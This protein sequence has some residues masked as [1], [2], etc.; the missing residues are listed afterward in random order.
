MPFLRNHLRNN[1]L[2]FLVL[3]LP[4]AILARFLQWGPVWIFVLSAVGLIPMAGYIGKAT[5]VLSVYTG[6]RIGGLLNATLGNAAELIITLVAIRAGLLDL[7][8]ASITG[9]IIGNLLLV[10]GMAMLVGGVKNGFQTFDRRHA[11]NNSVLLILAILALVI[12]SVF[13]G[14]IGDDGSPGV[15]SL[16][17][18]VAVVMMAL[19]GLG[20]LFAVKSAR[21]PIATETI[22]E[23]HHKPGMSLL[24]SILLLAVATL[25][26]V[27]LSELLVGE[28]EHVTENLGLSEFFLGIILV[29]IIGNV[30]EHLVA[31]QVAHRNHMELSVEIAISSSL[32]IAL[33]VAPLL[34][35]LS[36]AM[37]NPLTLIFNPF[38]LIALGAGVIISALVSLDGESNWLEG[39]ALMAV[40]LILGLS[41]FLLPG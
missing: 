30:A 39:A 11:S 41:F 35:F 2:S 12:P 16:S 1:P 28:V 21:S 31:V 34:V 19:Y 15:E 32:Q 7:V 9:S 36:L 26:V 33:F 25:G 17:L 5:E 14:S 8:K 20:I 40:Y 3:A 22:V 38:E 23:A 29:P 10:M 37:G 6:P 27:F 4:L 24:Q 13:S 18:G